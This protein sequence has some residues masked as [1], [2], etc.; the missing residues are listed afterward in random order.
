MLL[1]MSPNFDKVD[2]LCKQRAE[3]LYYCQTDNF[4]SLS[5][6][7]KKYT[8]EYHFNTYDTFFYFHKPKVDFGKVVKKVPGVDHHDDDKTLYNKNM[9]KNYKKCY[10]LIAEN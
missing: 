9:E 5:C 4:P 7:E 3:C 6:E 8:I 1:N 2:S 10:D